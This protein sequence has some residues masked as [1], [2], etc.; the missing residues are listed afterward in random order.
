MRW[1]VR[2]SSAV[3]ASRSGRRRSAAAARGPGAAR[4]MAAARGRSPLIVGRTG[5]GAGRFRPHR[6]LARAGPPRPSPHPL[7]SGGE[8]VGYYRPSV[9]RLG[10]YRLLEPVATGGMAEVY[11]AELPG[12]EGFVKQLA[13]KLLRGDLGGDPEMNRMFIQEAR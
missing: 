12:P 10:K 7:S 4:A 1:A 11:R 6:D 13:V 3:I 9:S 8:Q 5:G 2:P